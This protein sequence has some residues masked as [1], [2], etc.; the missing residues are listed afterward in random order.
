MSV[1]PVFQHVLAEDGDFPVR[2]A[3]TKGRINK[4]C[5]LAR[6]REVELHYIKEGKASYFLNNK[7]HLLQKRSLF[8]IRPLEIHCFNSCPDSYLEKCII[9]FFGSFLK[10]NLK[11]TLFLPDV[12]CHVYLSEDD[13]TNVEII[14]NRC[15]QEQ[16]KRE[17]YWTDII[18]ENLIELMFLIKRAG[19]RVTSPRRENPIINHLVDYLE[20][21]YSQSLNISILA[22]MYGFSNNYLSI[23]FKKHTGLGIK[24]YIL[25]RRVLEA[26]KLLETSPGLKSGAVADTVGFSNHLLFYR[27]FKKITGLTT[28][29]YRRIRYQAC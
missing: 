28:G 2:I 20:R 9:T 24:Q 1:K 16:N 13:A 26:K 22:K 21:N 8:I 10:D 29:A 17:I 27:A 6:H 4:T 12:P 14:I 23:L 19:K 11:N 7:N 15:L 18:R 3:W 25:Q 5:C